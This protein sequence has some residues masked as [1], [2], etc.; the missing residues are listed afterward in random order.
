MATV[1]VS[2]KV[3]KRELERLIRRGPGEAER[4]TQA[5]AVALRRDLQ[6]RYPRSR[7][8]PPGRTHSYTQVRE[9]RRGPYDW[10]VELPGNPAR[11]LIEGTR[12][13]II[14]G[15]PLAFLGRGGGLVFARIVHH[16]GTKPNDFAERAARAAASPF[17][18]LVAGVFGGR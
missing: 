3:D 16:P 10:A 4:V 8:P 14:R 11:F 2:V 5:R 6:D 15:N 17:A 7:N 18:R 13:H 1:S 9:V 12:P